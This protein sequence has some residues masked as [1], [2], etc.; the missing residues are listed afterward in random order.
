MTK[1]KIIRIAIV[2]STI[3][4]LLFVTLVVHIAMVSNPKNKPHYGIQL[5]RIDFNTA[6]DTKRVDEVCTYLKSIEGVG[7]IMYNKENNNVVFAHQLD[8]ISGQEVYEKLVAE[9]R[10]DAKRFY[11]TP[12]EIAKTAKCPVINDKGLLMSLAHKVQIYFL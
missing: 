2:I 10:V 6:L 11:L 1:K 5:S 12:E 4:L 9:K 3:S 8:V 7:S